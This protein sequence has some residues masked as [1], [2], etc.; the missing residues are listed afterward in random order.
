MVRYVMVVGVSAIGGLIATIRG[1]G[2]TV[3]N[4]KLAYSLITITV[5]V[6]RAVAIKL[7]IFKMVEWGFFM[8]PI[9]II[10]L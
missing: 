6:I 10:E 3:A 5:Y 4:E 8:R 1:A 7:I 9:Q 2:W